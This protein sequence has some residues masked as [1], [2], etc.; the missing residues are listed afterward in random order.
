MDSQQS[1]GTPNE[2]DRENDSSN[3]SSS[4]PSSPMDHDDGRNEWDDQEGNPSTPS[5]QTQSRGSNDD[6]EEREEGSSAVDRKRGENEE[7]DE[8]QKTAGR[9][10]QQPRTEPKR[11]LK[12]LD[13]ASVENIDQLLKVLKGSL[14]GG[15]CRPLLSLSFLWVSSPLSTCSSFLSFTLSCTPS[16]CSFPFLAR[17]GLTFFAFA[18][19]KPLSTFTIF[20]RGQFRASPRRSSQTLET[21]DGS[22]GLYGHECDRCSSLA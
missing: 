12:E 8:G 6:D 17:L 7:N 14:G 13:R 2:Q 20:R 11:R 18:D 9:G 22:F 4:S 1:P 15:E 3:D 5:A 16:F 19:N 10:R 21:Y